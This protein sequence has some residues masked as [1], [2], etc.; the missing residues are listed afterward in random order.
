MYFLLFTYFIR[1]Y[2]FYA[3]EFYMALSEGGEPV[4]RF[5]PYTIPDKTTNG[6]EG[7][8]R[9]CE[10]LEIFGE[11][12]IVLDQSSVRFDGPTCYG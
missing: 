6:V 10:S 1:Q 4:Y 2:V 3:T 9:H 12:C 7:L 5:A 11:P 8:W